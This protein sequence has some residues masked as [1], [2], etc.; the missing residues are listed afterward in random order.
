MFITPDDHI[1]IMAD[2]DGGGFSQDDLNRLADA[3]IRTIIRYVLWRQVEQEPGVFRWS[4]LC[5]GIEMDRKAGLKTMLGVYDLAP[6]F[7]PEGWYMQDEAGNRY[8]GSFY[9]N[10]LAP[11]VDAAW[12]AHKDFI[13]RCC[14][15]FAA[16]DV[17]PF[18]CTCHGGEVMFPD[19][20]PVKFPA[21][22]DMEAACRQI[23]IEEQSIFARCGHGELWTQLHPAFAGLPYTGNQH[24]GQIYRDLASCFPHHYRYGITYTMFANVMGRE[25]VP[26]QMRRHGIAMFCGS[27]YCEGLIANTDEAIRLGFRGFVTAPLHALTGHRS[28]EPWM[29]DAIRGSI[30]KWKDAA[31]SGR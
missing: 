9:A 23:M 15:Y 7:F 26:E 2:Q 8:A 18:R 16:N 13:A 21:G 28:L 11:W 22:Y 3:G 25:L 6:A 14:M 20:A 29:L 19:Y 30:R 4:E 1:L 24:M 27:E 5:R 17:M 31:D 10:M 12:N